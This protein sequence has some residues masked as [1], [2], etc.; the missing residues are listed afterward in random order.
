MVI[1]PQ[2]L[3]RYEFSLSDIEALCRRPTYRSIHINHRRRSG[4][5]YLLEG[6]C[7]LK[8]HDKK[9]QLSAG[10]LI[11]V[12]CGSQHTMSLN[13]PTVVFYRV[14]F[15]LHVKGEIALFS[16]HPTKLCDTLSHKCHEAILA[17]EEACTYYNN[18][19]LKNERL[20]ALLLILYTTPPSVYHSKIGAAVRYLDEHF[21]ERV[22]CPKLA[23][24]CFLSMAQFYNLFR[25]LLS[26]TP[27]EYR[28]RLLLHRAKA[29]LATDGVTV[30]EAAELLGFSSVAYFSRFFKKHTGLSPTAYAAQNKDF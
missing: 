17:L 12:P 4:F 28:N 21:T 16:N 10:S 9:I 30:S 20:C 19:V 5:I 7:I 6:E 3:G 2:E 1:V 8:S 27:L 11:Y 13:T 22:D 23:S 29:L 15:N 18:N 26:C 25:T 14:D 24:L